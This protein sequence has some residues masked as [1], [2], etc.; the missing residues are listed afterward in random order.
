ME[1]GRWEA[2]APSPTFLKKKI[3]RLTVKGRSHLSTLSA[4][5]LPPPPRNSSPPSVFTHCSLKCQ[6]KK[7]RS[8]R[9]QVPLSNSVQKRCVHINLPSRYRTLPGH[10][11]WT[12]PNLLTGHWVGSGA[13]NDSSPW[14]ICSEKQILPGIFYHS[15]TA[16]NFL[17]T[18]PL[19]SPYDFL[20]FNFHISP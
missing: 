6:S 20:K 16:K 8:C 11:V 17:T 2:L 18:V 19:K 3:P 5:N 15:R 1:S 10:K 7:S 14:D 13:P 4:P 9:A 12:K